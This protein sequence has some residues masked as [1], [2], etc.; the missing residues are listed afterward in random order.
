MVDLGDEGERYSL[1]KQG[2]GSMGL[3]E[4]L[5][6]SGR[7]RFVGCGSAGRGCAKRCKADTSPAARSPARTLPYALP[8]VAF[9]IISLYLR[10]NLCFLEAE[11]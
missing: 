1:G 2:F 4:A 6:G 10:H 9:S 3:L 7:R 8:L 5:G 11:W